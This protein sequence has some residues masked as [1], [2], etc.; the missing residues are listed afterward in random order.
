MQ[1]IEAQATWNVE[2][3]N[4][5]PVIKSQR[6]ALPGLSSDVLAL[7]ITLST[8]AN[9]LQDCGNKGCDVSHT[10]AT[11]LATIKATCVPFLSHC[12]Y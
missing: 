2:R 7:L 1:T 3:E 5:R 6:A 8:L 4:N 12:E 11:A 10:S 9:N